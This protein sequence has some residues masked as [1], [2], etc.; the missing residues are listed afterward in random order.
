MKRNMDKIFVVDLEATCWDDGMPASEVSDIIEIG[1]CSLNIKT[2]ELA[3]KE[4]VLVKPLRSRISGFCTDLT[5]ITPQMVKGAV[6]LVTAC[7]YIQNKYS[8]K[9][10]IWAAWG[11]FDRIRLE[12]EC[13][14]LGASF[15]YSQ[16]YIN[17]KT[18]FAINKRLDREIGLGRALKMCKMEFEGTH[19][20]GHD[21][22]WNTARLLK[23]ILL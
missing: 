18:L 23:E 4:S 2:G 7:N 19:H 9:Y 21:D 17:V 10:R 16:R 1:F 12:K 15:P 13:K 5:T 3:D 14:E 20:R 6:D 11:E 8:P 22:A